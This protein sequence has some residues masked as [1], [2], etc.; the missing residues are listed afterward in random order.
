MFGSKLGY[1]Q[2]IKFFLVKTEL[3]V[4]GGGVGAIAFQPPRPRFLIF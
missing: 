4:G 1:F 3:V 2:F